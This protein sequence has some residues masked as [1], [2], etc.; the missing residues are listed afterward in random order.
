MD[1]KSHKYIRDRSKF[2]E[3][4]IKMYINTLDTYDAL[5]GSDEKYSKADDAYSKYGNLRHDIFK[6]RLEAEKFDVETR[7]LRNEI[8]LK[9]T[10][11][12]PMTF[13][14]IL[15]I[16]VAVLSILI[17]QID[18]LDKYLPIIFWIVSMLGIIII[19]FLKDFRIKNDINKNL[20][21]ILD[22]RR[23]LD[24]QLICIKRAINRANLV[25]NK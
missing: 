13:L 6:L 9:K 2:D 3:K 19:Y 1:E 8:K 15:S 17:S 10:E 25:D 22:E 23:D 11:E 20:K 18:Q 12:S 5:I 24:L 7:I 14:T 4:I 16:I 21:M